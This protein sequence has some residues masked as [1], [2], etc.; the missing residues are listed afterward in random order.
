MKFGCNKSGLKCDEKW[1]NLK[2]TYDKVKTEIGKTGNSKV[3]WKFYEDF[4]EIYWKD[5]HFVPVATASST[6]DSIKRKLIDENYTTE[7]ECNGITKK[8]LSSGEK[9]KLKPTFTPLEIEMR[10]QKRHEEKMKLKSEIFEWFK[11]NYKKKSP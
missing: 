6:G 7:K 4:Q 5:P 1:R 8:N 2:K 9:K 10:K 11:E 3:S